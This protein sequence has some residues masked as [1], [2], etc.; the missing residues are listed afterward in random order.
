MALVVQK[1][2]TYE[3]QPNYGIS[4]GMQLTHMLLKPDGQIK[5][6]LQKIPLNFKYEFFDKQLAFS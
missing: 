3:N 4:Y 1:Y 6:S 2:F 5:V